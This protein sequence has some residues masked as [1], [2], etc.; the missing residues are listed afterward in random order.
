M[1]R[2]YGAGQNSH[3]ILHGTV[4]LVLGPQYVATLLGDLAGHTDEGLMPLWVTNAIVDANTSLKEESLG[5]AC[6]CQ[7]R[8]SRRFAP[9]L[10]V[11][12]NFLTAHSQC[13]CYIYIGTC[14]P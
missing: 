12:A 10:V 9:W 6:I 1:A 5:V 3:H 14:D 7:R 11:L 8:V 4:D 13:T 2:L